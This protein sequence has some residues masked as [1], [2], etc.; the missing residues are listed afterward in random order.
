MIHQKWWVIFFSNISIPSRDPLEEL[1][2]NFIHHGRT[3]NFK[4][5]QT[6]TWVYAYQK[7]NISD[8]II[9]S[10]FLSNIGQIG[11]CFHIEMDENICQK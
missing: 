4:F 7:W 2:D 1:W 11:S 8:E 3:L 10:K 9:N 5:L 6:V